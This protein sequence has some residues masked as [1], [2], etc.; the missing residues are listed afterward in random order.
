MKKIFLILAI[1]LS[2]AF[3][4]AAYASCSQSSYVGSVCVTAATSCPPGHM[5]A[6]GRSLSTKP[7]FGYGALFNVIGYTYGGGGDSF[8]IPDLRDRTMAGASTG[9]PVGSTAGSNALKL[10]PDNVPKLSVSIPI[11]RNAGMVGDGM[12]SNTPGTANSYL[13][14]APL[15]PNAAAIWSSGNSPVAA[16]LFGTAGNTAPAAID[17]RQA[18]VS[19]THCIK[20]G[21]AF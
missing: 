14:G 20:V 18:Q 12:N 19:L 10:T 2:I 13:T 21:A 6:D 4:P 11:Y 5:L 16:S 17:N 1:T 8:R 3:T 9:N 7:P 15:G